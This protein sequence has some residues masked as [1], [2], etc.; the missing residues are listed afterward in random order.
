MGN[1]EW[2]GRRGAAWGLCAI[3]AGVCALAMRWVF[4]VPIYQSPDEPHHLDYA[5]TI[6][7]GGFFHAIPIDPSRTIGAHAWTRYL[8]ERT[9][10]ETIFFNQSAKVPEG[11]GTRKYYRDLDRDAPPLSE[12]RIERA[13]AITRPSRAG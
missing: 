9:D 12:V 11:Y 8:L 13:A 7:D 3:V 6:R 5:L 2:I 10:A 1:R 4:L